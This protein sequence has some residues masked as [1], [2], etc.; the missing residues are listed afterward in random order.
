MVSAKRVERGSKG[1]ETEIFR[2]DGQVLLKTITD[3]FEK[4]LGPE[5]ESLIDQENK[6]IEE[7]RQS[8]REAEKQLQEAEK[9]SSEREKA[10]QEVKNLRT[11]LNQTQA[12]IDD[13]ES[14][15]HNEA[16]LRRLKQLRKNLKT[17]F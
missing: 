11:K 9:L 4:A 8:L 17:E 1:G 6:E 13:I 2:K 3:K 16:E 7:T 12:K 5:A 15:L 14:S 10:A